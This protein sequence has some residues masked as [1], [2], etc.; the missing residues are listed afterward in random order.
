MGQLYFTL[1]VGKCVSYQELLTVNTRLLPPTPMWP[2]N[3]AILEHVT[4]EDD[5]PVVLRLG[6]HLVSHLGH[7]CFPAAQKSFGKVVEWASGC[8][9]SCP[10]RCAVVTHARIIESVDSNVGIARTRNI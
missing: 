2:E 5:L 6:Y 1:P 8:S 10:N 4:K 7:I 9:A 3:E